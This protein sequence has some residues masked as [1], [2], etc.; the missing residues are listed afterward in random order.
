[1]EFIRSAIIDFISIDR[2]LKRKMVSDNE[3]VVEEGAI[4]IEGNHLY[5]SHSS[6][7]H[8]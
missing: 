1:M 3:S 4:Q 8:A 6:P 7:R 2:R 5:P